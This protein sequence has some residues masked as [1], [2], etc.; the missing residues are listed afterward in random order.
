M[1]SLKKGTLPVSLR[2]AGV[3]LLPKK[4]DLEDI[5]C[6]R[7]VSLLGVDYT[8]LSKSLTN[9]IKL[10]ISSVNHAYQSYCIPGRTIFDNVFL[11]QDLISFAKLHKI[12]I[13]FVSLDQEKAFDQVDHGFLFK[14]LEDFGFGPSIIAYIRLLYTD[15]YSM[16][17]ING[18]LTRPFRVSRGIRQGCGLS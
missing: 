7:P 18:T 14:C 13:G 17:K 10:Y 8:R 1:E 9:I 16:L 6:W 11:I 4:G 12:N 3:T 15:T 5:R 2:R